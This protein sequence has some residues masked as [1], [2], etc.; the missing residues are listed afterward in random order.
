[1]VRRLSARIRLVSRQTA[2]PLLVKPAM[3]LIFAMLALLTVALATL[4][5]WPYSREWTFYPAGA[6]SAIV[7][8]LVLL[9]IIGRL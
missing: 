7:V 9:V 1:V 8:A 3:E 2:R 6:C 4:P 5:T